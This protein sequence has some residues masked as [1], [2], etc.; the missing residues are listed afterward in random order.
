MCEDYLANKPDYKRGRMPTTLT[1]F[2]SIRDIIDENVEVVHGIEIPLFSHRLKT[3]GRCDLFCRFQGMYTI[4]DFKT[5]TKP[6][7][8]EWIE[9]YF[10]QTTAYAIMVEEMYQDYFDT[11]IKIPQLAI[12]IAVEDD[13]QPCQLF[14]K[15]TADYRERVFETFDIY[16]EQYTIPVI[17]QSTAG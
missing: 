14:V 4:A 13:D 11:P 2:K 16:H 1:L 9:N 5:S 8:E 10:L 6:K 12:I 7:K 3:A 15:R 17:E